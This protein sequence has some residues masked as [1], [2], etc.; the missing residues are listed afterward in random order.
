MTFRWELVRPSLDYP[1]IPYHGLLR[2]SAE[3]T[4][5]KW[6][7]VHHHQALTF[8]EIEGLSNSL[9]H[10]LLGLQVKKGD[11][12][13]LFMTNRPEY[14]ISFAAASKIGEVS[15]EVDTVK[16]AVAA[17]KSDLEK[18][19]A[20]L[21]SVRGDLGEQSGLIATNGREL[22]AL[23][24]LGVGLRLP[25]QGLAV[26]VTGAAAAPRGW[27]PIQVIEREGGRRLAGHWRRDAGSVLTIVAA[28]PCREPS[29][30]PSTL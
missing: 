17:N 11:R 19:I 23:K 8:R 22:S 25:L 27:R 14:L 1:R 28:P 30:L 12:I 7:T 10:A 3:R 21:K 26:D 16:Q 15:T 2:R 5:D 20:E 13:A 9:A 29:V 18:T 4:P 24:A 6:A